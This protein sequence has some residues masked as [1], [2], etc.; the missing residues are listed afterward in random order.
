MKPRSGFLCF[1]A[2]VASCAC[3]RGQ[4]TMPGALAPPLNPPVALTA[5]V[6]VTTNSSNGFGAVSQ[7]QRGKYY[8]SSAGQ[9]RQ[10][11]AATST[12]V[13]P[14]GRT[15]VTL[16]HN[17]SE[18]LLTQLSPAPPKPTSLPVPQP[19]LPPTSAE[20]LGTS[21]INGYSAH[22]RRITSPNPSGLKLGVVITEVWTST[23]LGLPLLMKQTSLAGET[24]QEFQN[25]QLGEP[26]ADLFAVPP[27]YNVRQSTAVPTKS[28]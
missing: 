14:Q 3:A 23:E 9:T 13:D 6:T 25:I 17:K 5:D 10:D 28:N 2:V 12:I 19:V 27:G 18:A 8:R 22:G 24:V 7:T 4:F 15:I 11:R 16:N 26:S 1:A 20:D 21:V